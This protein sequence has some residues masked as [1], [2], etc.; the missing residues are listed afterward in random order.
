MS[1]NKWL[2]LP[3]LFVFSGCTNT[4]WWDYRDDPYLAEMANSGEIGA[5]K[6]I[7]S[8]YPEDRQL[9]LRILAELSS[10]ARK[11]GNYQAA[12]RMVDVIINKYHAESNAEVRYS[13]ISLCAPIA[14][15]GSREMLEFLQERIALGEYPGTAAISIAELRPPGAA[16]IILPLTRHP[17]H[18]VRYQAALALIMVADYKTFETVRKIWLSMVAPPWPETL[19][20][21]PLREAREL[22]QVKGEQAFRRSF[23]N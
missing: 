12:D 21:M 19:D 9:A 10:R 17:S 8:A 20:G 18:T 1:F 22:M 7:N 13:I 3:L 2:I 5:L 15:P 23:Q 16:G 6:K 4:M 11:A 14:G